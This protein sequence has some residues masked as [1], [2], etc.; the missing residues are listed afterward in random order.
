MGLSEAFPEKI[1]VDL[2]E[3]IFLG[4]MIQLA[5]SISFLVTLPLAISSSTHAP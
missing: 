1:P 3:E 4:R 2:N 5:L